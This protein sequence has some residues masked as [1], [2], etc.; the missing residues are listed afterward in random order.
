MA[1][2]AA[3]NHGRTGDATVVSDAGFATVSGTARRQLGQ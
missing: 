1:R 3:I 2:T